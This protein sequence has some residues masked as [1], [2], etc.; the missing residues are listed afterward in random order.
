MGIEMNTQRIKE[1]MDFLTREIVPGNTICIYQNNREVFR[2]SSGYADEENHIPMSDDRLVNIYS[3]SK[4]TT[5]TAALQ[6]LE[7]GIYLLDDPLGEYI[8]EFKQMYVKDK[9]GNITEAK[10]QITLRNLFTM[11][12]GLNYNLNSEGIQKAAK[13]T[14][15]KMDTVTVAKC[16]AE[17]PLD[18]E[19]GEHWQYSLCH[20]VLAAFVEVLS[21]ERFS[22]Y[23][24]KNIFEPVGIQEAYYHTDAEIQSR[25]ANQ[26]ILTTDGEID[27]VD[28]QIR[29]ETL[30]GK[31]ENVGKGNDFA[32]GEQ[33]D[34]GGAGITIAVP[35]YAKLA[36]A[37]AQ[38]GKA[39][40]GERI[41][42]KGTVELMRT[43]QLSGQPLMDFNW[44]ALRGYGYGLGVR[45]CLSKSVA[46]STGGIG[47]LGWCGAAGGTLLADPDSG[48]GFFYAHHMLN[49][50]ETYYF[51]RLRNVVCSSMD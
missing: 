33:Y 2:Y 5:V 19:P 34:S 15:G 25:M 18:F 20:D 8:P 3:C 37:L 39:A 22:D 48:L 9:N 27:L 51:P 41:L 21:G 45:T 38:F 44:K 31:L 11:T 35:E 6:L 4:V 49:P 14:N 32:L 1:F 43:N 46:S 42:A 10:K 30:K 7:K 40:T 36:N 29:G 12:A 28:A 23:V 24:R 50:Q 17:Q 26:Y 16:L 13:L 47:E